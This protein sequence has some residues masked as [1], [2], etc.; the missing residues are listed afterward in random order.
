MFATI[1]ESVLSRMK[2]LEALYLQDQQNKRPYD[3][4]LHQVS[5]ETGR[6]LALMG[7]Y[8]PA[9]SFVEFGTSGGYSALWTSLVAKEKGK[10]IHTF[11]RSP[12][13]IEI[14]KET[15]EKAGLEDVIELHEGDAVEGAKEVR[16]IGFCFLDCN[17]EYYLDIWYKI[18]SMFVP[19]GILL[20]DNVISHEEVLIDFLVAVKENE[21]FDDV[22]VPIGKGVLMA[23]YTGSS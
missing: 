20:A 4:R 18:K 2:E 10:K 19:G 15:I 13:K 22:V 5:P 12:G 8:V 14:A 11:E 1:P 21:N 9:G 3:L 16:D 7:Q 17:K 6:F 23:R